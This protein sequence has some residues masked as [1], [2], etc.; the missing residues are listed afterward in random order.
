MRRIAD[1][2]AFSSSPLLA[3]GVLVL[4]LLAARPQATPERGRIGSFDSV[5]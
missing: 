2:R 1:P 3:G 5:R 4:I